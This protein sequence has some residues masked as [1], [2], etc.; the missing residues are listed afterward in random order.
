MSIK[1]NILL[2]KKVPYFEKIITKI[3]LNNYEY[4]NPPTFKDFTFKDMTPNNQGNPLVKRIS[5]QDGEKLEILVREG[6]LEANSIGE[7][8]IVS[9]LIGI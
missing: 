3:S 2:E 7:K 9:G 4:I 6:I 1:E 8:N 5:D